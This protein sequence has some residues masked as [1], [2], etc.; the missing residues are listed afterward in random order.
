[1]LK[2]YL[3]FFQLYTVENKNP[4]FSYL[5]F[6]YFYVKLTYRCHRWLEI[7]F[8]NCDGKKWQHDTILFSDFKI[9]DNGSIRFTSSST[10]LVPLSWVYVRMI[11][12]GHIYQNNTANFMISLLDPTTWDDG[13]DEI[14]LCPIALS[15]APKGVGFFLMDPWYLAV[16]F[17]FDGSMKSIY[18]CITLSDKVFFICYCLYDSSIKYTLYM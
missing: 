1:M 15:S 5:Q 16:G 18:T 7:I 13:D 3:S 4:F 17:F 6:I 12:F 9:S 14:V 2:W 10:Y 11:V 8:F